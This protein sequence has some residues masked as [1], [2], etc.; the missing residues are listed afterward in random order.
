VSSLMPNATSTAT[1]TP[2][3]LGVDRRV[4]VRY[5]CDLESTCHSGRGPDELS[6][7]ARVRDISR[8]GLNLQLNRSFEQGSVLSVDLP[9]GADLSPRT[10]Q[11]KV[12]HAQNQGPGKWSLGCAFEK[13]LDEGDLLAFQVKKPVVPSDDKRAWIRF[14]CDGERPAHAT[15]LINP[16]HKIQ[17]RVLNI[18]PGGIG[19]AT[20]RHY[21]PGTSLK[22]E[23]IDASGRT[24]RPIQA[25][26][27]HSTSS[28]AEDWTIGCSFDTPLTEEDVASL[29]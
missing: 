1:M 2:T 7:S 17:A 16:H 25:H 27:V 23:L 5:F 29:L 15:V 24:S 12:V 8:G 11:V 13:P 4:W 22:L 3:S 20:Q 19:L 9:L 14:S 26:V 10:L 28:G 18:S 6:W 21:D